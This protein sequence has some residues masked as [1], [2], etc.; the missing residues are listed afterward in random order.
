MARDFEDMHDV[1]NL[2]DD[3]LRALVRTQLAE[4]HGIDADDIGVRM[5]GGTVVLSG[6]VGTEGEM[7]IA[8]HLVTDVLGLVDVRNEL[9]VDALRRAESPLAID[10]AEAE[11]DV[12]AG[13]QLGDRARPLSDSAA[14]LEEDLDA[15]LYGTSDMQ[16][17][18]EGGMSYTPPTSPTQEGFGGTESTPGSFGEDH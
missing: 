2:D 16:K 13:A 4:N 12:T 6:R 8:E 10:D 5:D 7:R 15:R 17:A 14:H 11:E 1:E 9:V 3:E 18:I